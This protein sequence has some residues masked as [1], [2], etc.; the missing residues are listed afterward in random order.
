MKPSEVKE[1]LQ[2]TLSSQRF[3]VYN[4]VRNEQPHSALVGFAI[5]P[6]L[7]KIIILTP[8][9]TRKYINTQMN[10]RVNLFVSTTTNDPKDLDSAITISVLGKAE[11]SDKLSK[12][13]VSE[14][15]AI[16]LQKNKY[17]EP[18]AEKMEDMIVINAETFELTK[19]YQKSVIQTKKDI[20]SIRVR[21]IP[22]KPV[23]P[24]IARGKAVKL[25]KI[26]EIKE[27]HLDSIIIVENILESE[28]IP[29]LICKGLIIVNDLPD[30]IK[31]QLSGLPTI[32]SIGSGI[33]LILPGEEISI[34]GSLG[35]VIS[36][37]I[38]Y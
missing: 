27:E 25:D 4:T 37:Q 28:V 2:T 23:I 13:L 18:L 31:N 8:K 14:Y 5:T 1:L 32:K 15:K 22:G 3:G 20:S 29:K 6:D 34:N 35:I 26:S 21:Q 19:N 17:M 9:N 36:H 7:S 16:Y 38:K 11:V 30:K 10:Q 12:D 24:G 33:D